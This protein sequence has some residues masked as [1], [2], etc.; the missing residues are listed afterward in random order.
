MSWACS[1]FFQFEPSRTKF[2]GRTTIYCSPFAPPIE[3]RVL[4][5]HLLLAHL[6]A[7]PSLST[8]S[9]VLAEN[10]RVTR[11]VSKLAAQGCGKPCS[12]SVCSSIVFNLAL[13]AVIIRRPLSNRTTSVNAG[14]PFSATRKQNAS[15]PPP[16]K[17]AVSVPLPYKTG[18][19][20]IPRGAPRTLEERKRLRK[21]RLA[22]FRRARA[23]Q[24]KNLPRLKLSSSPAVAC[25]AQ[26]TREYVGR[27]TSFHRVVSSPA[28]LAPPATSYGGQVLD[29]GMFAVVPEIRE[30]APLPWDMWRPTDRPENDAQVDA[31]MLFVPPTTSSGDLYPQDMARYFPV[32]WRKA[33]EDHAREVRAK[34]KRRLAKV[35]T[36]GGRRRL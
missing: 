2:E 3:S 5:D 27:R 4:F 21:Q 20:F 17:P 1:E 22:F 29:S 19:G 11:S 28:L 9:L 8:T 13:A 6:S 31:S 34:R 35:R 33:L 18:F 16:P 12:S 14:I 24:R 7:M 23:Y 36:V 15:K 26:Y 30:V 25:E 32:V 10:M